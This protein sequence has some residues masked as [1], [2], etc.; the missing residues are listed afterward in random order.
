MLPQASGIREQTTDLQFIKK[1]FF[2]C[3]LDGCY[4]KIAIQMRGE[5]G[6]RGMGEGDGGGGWGRGIREGDG[7]SPSV[8]LVLF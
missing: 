6:G 1:Y 4:D 5:G 2:V 7:L 3:P 8:R